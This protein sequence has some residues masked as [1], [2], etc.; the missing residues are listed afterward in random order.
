MSQAATL[1]VNL[2]I[3]QAA[4]AFPQPPWPLPPGWTVNFE[5]SV[6]YPRLVLAAGSI[7]LLDFALLPTD[8]AQ[9]LLVVLDPVDDAGLALTAGVT[10]TLAGGTSAVIRLPIAGGTFALGAPGTTTG[11]TGL[12]IT[13]T[14]PAVLRVFAAG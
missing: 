12:S 10:I 9:V 6:C 11:V 7:Q 1:T 13:A 14:A 8:G 5:Q 3:P 4:G 2:A